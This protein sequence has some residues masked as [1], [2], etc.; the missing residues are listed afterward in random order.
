MRTLRRLAGN[1]IISTIETV[2]SIK[3]PDDERYEIL[4]GAL[5]KADRSLNKNVL[6]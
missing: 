2:Y 1:D 5:Q 4:R 3:I 6:E